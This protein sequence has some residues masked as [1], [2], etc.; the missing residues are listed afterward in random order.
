MPSAAAQAKAIARNRGERLS[1]CRRPAGPG[2]GAR[3]L[4]SS[5][6][7]RRGMRPA[8]RSEDRGG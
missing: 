3:A 4:T 6:S 2:L 5:P 1:E 7:T 8:S